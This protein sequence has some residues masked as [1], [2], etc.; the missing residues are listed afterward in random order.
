MGNFL[1]G[2]TTKSTTP[3]RM[4]RGCP[5]RLNNGRLALLPLLTPW[6][7]DLQHGTEQRQAVRESIT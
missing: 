6:A 7:S 3:Y 1:L 5:Y 4:Q 2:C